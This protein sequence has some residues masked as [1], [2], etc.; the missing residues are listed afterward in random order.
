MIEEMERIL[1][2]LGDFIYKS[3]YP[4]SFVQKMEL[5]NIWHKIEK[6]KKKMEKKADR[7]WIE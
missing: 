1:D 5:E 2:D 4:L 3:P 7:R 6:L